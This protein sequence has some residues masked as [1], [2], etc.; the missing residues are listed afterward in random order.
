MDVTEAHQQAGAH[1]Y[2]AKTTSASSLEAEAQDKNTSSLWLSAAG[3]Y[4]RKGNK[5]KFAESL[6]NAALTSEDEV[7]HT[8]AEHVEE[9]YDLIHKSTT[10]M[11]DTARRI[12]A[13][14]IYRHFRK[15]DSYCTVEGLIEGLKE[16]PT[17]HH[18]NFLTIAATN[19]TIEAYKLA[20]SED[21]KKFE[22]R[23]KGLK[24][25]HFYLSHGQENSMGWVITIV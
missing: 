12:F 6:R 20:T 22:E 13:Q 7:V 17:Q 19:L 16:K 1:L 15:E 11:T 9:T 25:C 10:E 24:R 23:V 21:T 3:A 8:L 4:A 18:G 2:N 5:Q 14:E